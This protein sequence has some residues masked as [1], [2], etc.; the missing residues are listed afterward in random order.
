MAEDSNK[1]KNREK[2]KEKFKELMLT[3]HTVMSEID[4]IF[5]TRKKEVLEGKIK[6][7]DHGFK[8]RKEFLTKVEAD[9]IASAAKSL[10][11]S[12]GLVRDRWRV[13]TLPMPIFV[14]MEEGEIAF[15]KA[16][17]ATTLN[18]SPDDTTSI[19]AATRIAQKMIGTDDV[20][21]IKKAV[22]EEARVIWN[23]STA[24]M[25]L[26]FNQATASAPKE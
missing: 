7:M 15:P 4:K 11:S 14:A 5:E 24:V 1:I 22:A 25:D 6:T 26:L 19:E 17:L 9:A 3:F 10:N 13:I 18:F 21:E 20:E 23:P 8:C 16:K 12:L 2:N